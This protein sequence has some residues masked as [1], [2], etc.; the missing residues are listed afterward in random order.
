MLRRLRR[1]GF[2]EEWPGKIEGQVQRQEWAQHI[3]EVER[4]SLVLWGKW[5]MKLRRWGW[6]RA[7]SPMLEVKEKSCPKWANI[8]KDVCICGWGGGIQWITHSLSVFNTGQ[9]VNCCLKRSR[10]CYI[11]Q[12]FFRKLNYYIY[13]N[14]R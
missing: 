1:H 10:N 8:C 7:R 2:R 11:G 14:F 13:I 5:G 4:R 6:Q 3:W 12:K 9:G